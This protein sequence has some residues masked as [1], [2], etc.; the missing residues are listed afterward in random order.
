MNVRR[1]HSLVL[2]LSLLLMGTAAPAFAGEKE[3]KSLY[4]RLGGIPAIAAVVDDFV[5]N[6]V[7]NKTVT[8]NPRVVE[9]LGRVGVPALKYYLTEQIAAA[10]GGPQK[11][12]GKSMLDAHRGQMISEKEWDATVQEL[13][14]SLDR[15][16]VPKKEQNEL[17]G[18]IAP[19]KPDIV[20]R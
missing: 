7:Q 16:K 9:A 14:K 1:G 8:A 12:T 20:G 4:Q 11:Y 2:A 15:F 19:A 17:I 6:L 3:E 18:L 5:N 10:S 13:M